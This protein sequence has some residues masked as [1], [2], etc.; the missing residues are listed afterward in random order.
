MN[1]TFLSMDAWI[2]SI[3]L[4]WMRCDAMQC[5]FPTD[6]APLIQVTFLN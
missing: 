2:S 5:T 6:N 4:D 3:A 1:G